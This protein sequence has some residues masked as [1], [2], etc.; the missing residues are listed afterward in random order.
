MSDFAM[1]AVGFLYFTGLGL[2]M[3]AIAKWRLS[4]KRGN[5]S[6]GANTQSGDTP[7]QNSTNSSAE[8]SERGLEGWEK[9]GYSNYDQYR[10]AKEEE[11]ERRQEAWDNSLSKKAIDFFRD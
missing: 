6:N 5:T 4:S 8:T 9:Q 3:V 2:L 11:E 1:A 7:P 10:E